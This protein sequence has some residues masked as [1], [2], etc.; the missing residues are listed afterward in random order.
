MGLE[1]ASTTVHRVDKMIKA[2]PSRTALKDGRGHVLTYVQM[3]DRSNSIAVELL[4]IGVSKGDVVALFQEPSA[5]WMCSMLAIFRVGAT[6][7]PLDLKNGMPRLSGSVSVG[8]PRFILVDRYTAELVPSLHLRKDAVTTNVSSIITQIDCHV[9]NFATADGV[10]AI[11]F[12]SGST[13]APKGVILSHSCLVANA[14]ATERSWNVGAN[15][16]LQQSTLSFDFSLHQILTAFTNGGTLYVVPPEKRGDPVEITDIILKEKITCTIAT[17]TEYGMWL[18]LGRETLA[19]STT[20]KWAISGGEALSKPIIQGLA[21]LDVTGLRFCNTYG[22]VEATIALSM[23]EVF[24]RN[25][26]LEKPIPTGYVLPTYSVYILDENLN[27]LPVGVPGEVVVGGPGLSDG[28]LD[29]H[30]LTSQKFIANP[31]HSTETGTQAPT[32]LYRTGDRGR[33]DMDGRLFHEGRIN[34]DRQ[35]KLNG[36]RVELEEVE[37]AI[38]STAKGAVKQ[39][40]VSIRAEPESKL[41]VAYVVLSEQAAMYGAQFVVNL[42]AA[43]PIAQYMRPAVFVPLQSIPVSPHGKTD[44]IA[45]SQIPLPSGRGGDIQT[46]PE[47]EALTDTERRLGDL[48]TRILPPQGVDLH[49]GSDFFHMG[50]NSLLLVNLQRLLKDVFHA[51][52]RLVDLISASTL[53]AMSKVIEST[54]TRGSVNWDLETAVPDSWPSV[55]SPVK[56]IGKNSLTIVLTGATGYLGRHLLSRL[57]AD[58]RVVKI[59]CLVRSESRIAISSPKISTMTCNLAEPNLGLSSTDFTELSQ[60]A[61]VIIHCA[62]NRS[63]W[64]DYEVLRPVNFNSVKD[65]ARLALQRGVPLHFFSSGAVSMYD[66][67]VPAADGGDGYIA[68]KWASERLLHNVARQLNLPVC[69]HSPNPAP[70]DKPSVLDPSVIGELVDCAERVGHRPDFNGFSGHIDLIDT[71]QFLDTV[72]HVVFDGLHIIADTRIATLGRV[73]YDGVVRLNI[74]DSRATVNLIQRWISLPTMDLL[75]WMGQAKAHG[76]PFVLSSQNLTMTSGS[77][78]IVSRR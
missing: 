73:P 44:L 60:I 38:I 78:T 54:T 46:V 2:H 7:M 1:W 70:V 55:V 30:K 42:R 27:P 4:K 52:P 32:R 71:A 8:K 47:L 34:G 25:I 43:L 3:K 22:P 66:G 10:A 69:I 56:S 49:A 14:E 19:K 72:C 41:L 18:Q 50:G 29:L 31:F 59:V 21:A 40:V 74:D 28:Y 35:V 63:F 61:D 58:S 11:I 48:W 76:F 12:T 51:A 39:V 13:G 6:Y 64:D 17:P 68:T 65:L 26:D 20:W 57:V 9:P 45:L 15:T 16:V 67:T 5:D 77:R 24:Y 37:A 75:A 33:L 62:A 36:I 23:G 53:H